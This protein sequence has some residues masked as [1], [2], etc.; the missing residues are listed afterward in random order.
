MLKNLTMLFIGLLLSSTTTAQ[1]IPGTR[2]S[3]QHLNGDS[4]LI[5]VIFYW[6]CSTILPPTFVKVC[7]SSDSCS[8]QDSI[9][10]PVTVQGVQ[11]P[12][13]NLL[14][15]VNT[16][17]NGGS[18]F[19]VEKWTYS[20]TLQLPFQCTDWILSCTNAEDYD[21]LSATYYPNYFNST[22]INNKY[23]QDN[24]S[25]EINTDPGFQYCVTQMS[26]I[27]FGA[28][29]FDGDSLVYQL[30]S[31]QLDSQQCPLNPII[32]IFPNTISY[33]NSIYPFVPVSVD[34][35]NGLMSF[36]PPYLLVGMVS[37]S[38]HE[39]RNG[40]KINS[41][42]VQQQV[43]FV[44][45]CLNTALNENHDSDFSVS[46]NP[47]KNLLEINLKNMDGPI[48]IVISNIT[49]QYIKN[50]HIQHHSNTSYSVDVTDL[51]AGVY[52]ITITGPQSTSVERF[53][54]L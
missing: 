39:F 35:Q 29:D 44:A 17:C 18:G 42:L 38:I 30:D 20:D 3:Y 48:N 9:M 52:T 14:P 28:T 53:I 27:N 12:P 22:K 47:V 13:F 34:P 37:V 2:I 41:T 6:D 7:F 15:I 32:S 45:G 23:F 36:I 40:I 8:V 5:K 50:Q 19:G 1:P 46:P 43:N 10:L 16:S 31:V 49:G 24:S 54:K 21:W 33:L 25:I 26:Y 51:Q 4:Y 11:L